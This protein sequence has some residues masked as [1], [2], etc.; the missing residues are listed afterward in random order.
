VLAPC[1]QGFLSAD[2]ILV[3]ELGP[4]LL[5]AYLAGDLKA[6]FNAY[7]KLIR[8]YSIFDIAALPTGFNRWVRR[9]CGYSGSPARTSGPPTFH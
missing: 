7:S 9:P 2:G 8:N 1:G 3:P 4:E 6:A 5:D